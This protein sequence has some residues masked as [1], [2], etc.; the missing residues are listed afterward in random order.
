MVPTRKI[1]TSSKVVLYKL[2]RIKRKKRVR[3]KVLV[4]GGI[5]FVLGWVMIGALYL[6]NESPQYEIKEITVEGN[7]KTR[8]S[9]ISSLVTAEMTNKNWWRPIV[10]HRN[11]LFWKWGEDANVSRVLPEIEAIHIEK[12]RDRKKI[13]LH[14]EEKRVVA[15]W[16]TVRACYGVD[17][18]GSA[19]TKMPRSEGYLFLTI[20]S[21]TAEEPEAK[22]WQTIK[23]T[24]EKLKNVG[25]YAKHIRVERAEHTIEWYVET[26]RGNRFIF[27]LE[28][29]PQNIE[30][31]ITELKKV[32]PLNIIE[33]A[34][35]R[36]EG[37]IYY[38]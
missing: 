6:I 32:V 11:T 33:E 29:T 35:F 14:V 22:H 5:F 24:V 12:D 18:K 3:K 28:S 19:F 23:K 38:K 30:N 2:M 7:K 10:G 9:L 26:A 25:V 36:V 15:V 13:T 34:D 31:I 1:S 27:N 8:A 16:C 37:K 21:N 4:T 20:T 17:E